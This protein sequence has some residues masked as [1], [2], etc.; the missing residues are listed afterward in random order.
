[1]PNIL[2][3]LNKYLMSVWKAYPV[4]VLALPL[5]CSVA[6]SKFLVLSDVSVLRWDMGTKVASQLGLVFK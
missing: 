6:L 4:P 1:M 2:Q 5:T 3:Q